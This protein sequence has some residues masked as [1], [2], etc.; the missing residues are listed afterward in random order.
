LLILSKVSSILSHGGDFDAEEG[1]VGWSGGRDAD[2][3]GGVAG[4]GDG[5]RDG[6]GP[7]GEVGGGFGEGGEAGDGGFFAGVGDAGGGGVAIFGWD[8]DDLVGWRAGDEG[9]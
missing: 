9:V 1:F 4:G 3:L 5:L 6:E 7:G 8:G 2:I